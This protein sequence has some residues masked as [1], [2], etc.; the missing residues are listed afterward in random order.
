[1]STF[2]Q[3]GHRTVEIDDIVKFARKQGS[4]RADDAR[5][6]GVSRTLLPYLERKGVLRRITRGTYMLVDHIPER[7][8][9]VEIAAAAPRGVICLLSA[10]QYHELTTQMPNE[11]WVAVKRGSRVPAATGLRLQV[12]RLTGTMFSAGIEEHTAD[13]ITIRVYSAAKTVVDCFRFR[14]RIGLDV[15]RE[16]LIDSLA[17]RE[18]TRDQIWGYARLCRMARVMG[19]YLEMTR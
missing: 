4:V 14:N 15:A 8:G 3:W 2:C 7:A 12:V 17:R 6:L 18:A 16:A 19:P 10:L 1:M 5:K 11:A 9:F 13:G